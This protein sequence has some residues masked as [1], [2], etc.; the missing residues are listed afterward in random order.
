MSDALAALLSRT[1]EARDALAAALR[2]TLAGACCQFSLSPEKSYPAWVRV[3]LVAPNS[4]EHVELSLITECIRS[5]SVVHSAILKKGRTKVTLTRV[6]EFTA[7]HVEE[8]ARYAIG[9]GQIPGS[10]LRRRS[11]YR[12]LFAVIVK[13]IRVAPR[14]MLSAQR[15]A[16][17][18]GVLRGFVRRIRPI[19][20]EIPR[21]SDYSIEVPFQWLT[22]VSSLPRLVAVC[23]IF[24]PDML[25]EM[26]RYLRNIPLPFDVV[27][28][29]DT[30]AKR[31][32]ILAGFDDWKPGA[33]DVRVMQNRGR[34]VGPLLVGFR[35]IYD[36]YDYVLHIHS[37]SSGH[38]CLLS[39]WRQ[40][41]LETLLGSPHVVNSVFDAFEGN[42]NL[43]MVGP[44]RFEGVRGVGWSANYRTCRRLAR[45]MG[46]MISETPSVDFPAG[47]MFW[48]R[49]SALRPL[50]Q[51]GLQ[52]A[53]FPKELGQVDGT[54]AH[55]LER[56]FYVACECAG[57]E[58][59]TISRSGLFEM[60]GP[61]VLLDSRET[62]CN[63]MARRLAARMAG[64]RTEEHRDS[65]A[66]ILTH[67][68][69]EDGKPQRIV[70]SA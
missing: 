59:I 1:N 42:R 55:A 54:L 65:R 53:D 51:L 13:G 52:F 48:A 15:V 61:A 27:I 36:R 20:V 57:L 44:S 28:S 25:P 11:L 45:R 58:W 14:L 68:D 34:D 6:S 47:S 38:A 23:H 46:V 70:G 3:E 21:L 4:R 32:T 62:L 9:M 7:G 64:P 5:G 26:T 67:T 33:V 24:Y 56:L 30:P 16:N 43:G 8:W 63:F 40:F 18:T 17:K 2:Q 66:R 35:D 37:K 69:L 12:A 49:T 22:S 10:A 19:D 29:T 39:Q 60:P 31:S 41:L 50:L